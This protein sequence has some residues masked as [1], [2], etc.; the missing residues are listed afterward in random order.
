MS[1]LSTVSE[2]KPEEKQAGASAQSP[3]S[4]P[5]VPGAGTPLPN[6]GKKK[7]RAD[8]KRKKLIKRI[9]W[10]SVSAVVVGGI[11]YGLFK[12]FSAK[13]EVVYST[14]V[15]SYGPVESMIYGSGSTKAKQSE[16]ITVSAKGEVKE[17]YVNTGDSVKAGTPLFS[18]KGESLEED[19]EA[20]EKELK[21]YEE[22]I[23]DIN[24]NIANLSLTAPFD[25]KALDVTVKLDDVVT[26]GQ[27]L[28][29]YIDDSKM[30]LKLYF[31]Y[32]Y[33][34]DI[35][36][37]MTAQVS[38]P[39]TMASVKATV[40]KVELIKKVTAEGTMLFEVSLVMD[41]PGTLTK[42]MPA[43]ATISSSA[44]E[45]MMPSD[46]GKL[47]N[48]RETDI[49]AKAAGT[50]TAVNMH[51]YYSFSEGALL[52]SLKNDDY[53]TQLKTLET[54]MAKARQK[55][56][57]VQEQY[58]SL[59]KKASF[60]GVVVSSTLV[61]GQTVEAGTTVMSIANLSDM[62]IEAQVNEIDISKVSVG[63]N[64][65]INQDTYDGQKQ[66]AGTILS[67][68]MQGKNE[69]GV[70]FFPVIVS[71][72]NS[73][74]SIMPGMS[75]WFQI[76]AQQK[77]NCLIV[78]PQAL[79]NMPDGSLCVF[80][81]TEE[82]PENAVDTSQWEDIVPPGF[83]AVPVTVGI[84]NETSVEILSGITEGTEVYTQ[85]DTANNDNGGMK[86][87]AVMMG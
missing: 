82:K 43:T 45:K 21:D 37:G 65:T 80:V 75:I 71:V 68:S 17:V 9:V 31:S 39:S 5:P 2:S 73:D 86:G 13:E 52:L 35:K 70:S 32:A 26:V 76:T 33:E 6:G 83:F 25:G 15:A 47:E 53:G 74:G 55:M 41:N 40:E 84:S 44:G 81:K 4:E 8:P 18:I 36:K 49:S 1:E 69:N 28:G 34:K 79:K 59:E 51:D 11:A 56:S 87:G 7:K 3:I 62:T 64:V 60:D 54:S 85:N 22:Q 78:P 58:A 10:L 14:A 24:E 29:T 77:E 46:T 61:P 67:I 72:D 23:A 27:K 57:D 30:R 12:L 19:L 48:Y 38:I 66:I 50:V 16:D 42:D 20:A 63:M